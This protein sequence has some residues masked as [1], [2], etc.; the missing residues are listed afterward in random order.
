MIPIGYS[1]RSLARRPLTGTLTVVGVALVV[2]VFAATLMLETGVRDALA[3]NGSPHNAL[4]LRDG[5]TSETTSFIGRD[6]FRLLTASPEVAVASD[7][8]PM[9][10][11]ELMVINNLARIDQNGT[12]NVGIRGISPTSLAVRDTIKI[13]R[14]RLPQPGTLEVIVGAAAEGRYVGSRIG[15]S[16]AFARRSWPVVGIFTGDGS[17]FE[18]EIWADVQQLMDAYNRTVYSDA[19]LRLKEP[20]SLA[21]LTGKV[22]ADP[23][24]SSARVWR[25]DRFFD[26]QSESLRRFIVMLGS[27]VSVIFAIAAAFGATVTMYGQVARR[28]VEI[29]T[30][31]AIGFRRRTVL[32]VFLRE[33]ALLALSSALIGLLAASFLSLATFS[34]VNMQSFTQVVFHF[35]LGAGVV[36]DTLI[37][38]LAVGMLGGFL[39]AVR[40]ARLPIINAI[41]GGR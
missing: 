11:G 25:E 22:A 30:L 40:A 36:I 20:G 6:Q 21:T 35:H 1:I 41:R 7:G 4:V 31:R 16:L 33:S 8:S 38:T 13:V 34:S 18:S 28:I 12:A 32:T 2:F 23:A 17:A 15:E 29:G 27:F 3:K 5:A 19:V 10:A 26:S 9:I 24:L 39:P 14:G 37:F